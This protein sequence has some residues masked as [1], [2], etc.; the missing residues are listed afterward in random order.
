MD[1][2]REYIQNTP[3]ELLPSLHTLI[4]FKPLKTLPKFVSKEDKLEL[5]RMFLERG[6]D[7]NVREAIWDATPLHYSV[8]RSEHE[9]TK[10]FLEHGADPN[11]QENDKK[12]PLHCL[13]GCL[14]NRRWPSTDKAYEIITLFITKNADVGLKDKK[15]Q[16]VFHC[17]A[18]SLYDSAIAF[19]VCRLL[20]GDAARNRQAVCAVLMAHKRK[21]NEATIFSQ[22]PRR[23]LL[24]LLDIFG[25][26][27]IND[28]LAIEDQNK[29]TA[30]GIAQEKV[31]T[32][33]TDE[34]KEQWKK[35]VAL[36]TVHKK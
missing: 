35:V 33:T 31:D 27:W 21:G 9:Q 26:K 10:L 5:I 1:K 20:Q 14:G 18:N 23:L 15:N 8:F 30:A 6:V 12:T 3:P 22:V 2:A 13:M 32:A 24:Y 11:T 28:I 19:N 25:F 29:K 36:L 4:E 7:K 34:D 16:T 17:A